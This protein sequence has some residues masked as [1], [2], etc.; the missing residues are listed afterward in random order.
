L[1]AFSRRQVLHPR[2]VDLNSVI[3]GL[4]S[5]LDKIIGKDIEFKFLQAALDPVKADPK[6]IEHALMNLCLNA[7]DAM[8]GGGRLCI[9]TE[10]VELDESYCWFYPYVTPG[11]YTVIT[12]S[13]TGVGMDAGTRERVFEPFFTTKERGKST[14]MGLATVY[15]IVKQHGGF[16][17]VYSEP[18]QGSLFRVYL[19]TTDRATD[20]GTATKARSFCGNA[21]HRNDPAGGRPR[22]HPRNGPADAGQPRLPGAF[23]Q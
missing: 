8:P 7:R 15:G 20:A 3:S 10:M 22:I 1:L 12:V 23:R 21:R 9:E 11:R 14:G 5:F 18:S 19:P 4:V 6:Q 17:H 16:I 2:E 13:D